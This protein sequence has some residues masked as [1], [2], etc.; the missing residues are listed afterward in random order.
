MTTR[1]KKRKHAIKK[2]LSSKEESIKLL[3]KAGIITKDL[4]IHP[5]YKI[6]GD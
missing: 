4:S 2:S 6:E 5:R 3:K 1:D